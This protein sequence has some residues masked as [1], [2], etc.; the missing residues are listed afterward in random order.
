ML[1]TEI[2]REAALVS[3]EDHGRLGNA[4]GLVLNPQD[5]ERVANVLLAAARLLRA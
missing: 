4:A 1:L 2:D 3:L 5:A